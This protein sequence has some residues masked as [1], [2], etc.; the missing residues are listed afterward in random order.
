[1]VWCVLQAPVVSLAEQNQINISPSGAKTVIQCK[2]SITDFNF[3]IRDL[4]HDGVFVCAGQCK[5]L[6]APWMLLL[7]W[8]W[9]DKGVTL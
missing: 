2:Q 1:L 4:P 5:A 8:H 9:Q 3:Y 7:F 6:E